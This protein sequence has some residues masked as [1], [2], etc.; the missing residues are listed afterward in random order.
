MRQCD[1]S[2]KQHLH[3]GALHVSSDVTSER[4]RTAGRRGR[5][6][7]RPTSRTGT[8]SCPRPTPSSTHDL[9][10]FPGRIGVGQAQGDWVA[11]CRFRSSN[12]STHSPL[13]PRHAPS[14]ND[15]MTDMED[16]FPVEAPTPRDP[17]L[18]AEIPSFAPSLSSQNGHLRNGPRAFG[19]GQRRQLWSYNYLADCAPR[20][21]LNRSGSFSPEVIRIHPSRMFEA[22]EYS[23]VPVVDRANG[24]GRKAASSYVRTMS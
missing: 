14:R 24:S 19:R 23:A 22:V 20:P 2:A 3:P 1:R 17:R 7:R 5:R 15:R 12:H 6:S 18:H 4:G 21:V 11:T 13:T 10:P 9:G 8:G 16:H